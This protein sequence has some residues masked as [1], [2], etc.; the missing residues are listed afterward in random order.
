M[1]DAVFIGEALETKEFPAHKRGVPTKVR[2]RL[3]IK[4]EVPPG[5]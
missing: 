4:G 2:V 5:E 1:C 3:S